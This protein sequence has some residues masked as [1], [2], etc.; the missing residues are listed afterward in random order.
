MGPLGQILQQMN[1][2]FRQQSHAIADKLKADPSVRRFLEENPEVDD[3][4]F[5]LSLSKFFQYAKDSSNCANCPGLAKCPNDFEG[6]Y[7]KL[8]V[9]HFNG[10][11]EIID[12]KTP[13]NLQLAAMHKKKVK[14]RIQSFYVDERALS[15]GYN[16]AEILRKDLQRAPA[17]N[18]V[19]RYVNEA[20][21]NGLSPHGLYLEGSFGTGKTFLMGYLLHELALEGFT[22]VIVYMPDFVEDLKSMFQDGQKLKETT[23]MLK[24]CDLLI[25]DDIGAENLSPW[26]RDHVLG[27][28]LNYR[29]NR[30]PTF[31]T[32]N[33]NLDS[34]EQHLSFTSKDG[35][36]RHKGQRLMDRI[37]PFVD[38]VPVRGDNQRG[39]HR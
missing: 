29:M 34:L 1:P 32:S 4:R 33:Y 27:S 7:S 17:V 31:Y 35:E 15:E 8:S 18:Q 25:F 5:M 21:Q 26:V 37:R 14:E 6:H 13:C 38:V 2:S 9:E 39:K 24:N 11:P 3:T 12:K 30:K 36:E 16:V 22:G 23:E 19:F 28:I 10:E 20:K